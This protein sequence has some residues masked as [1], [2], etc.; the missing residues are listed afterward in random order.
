[1]DI[2]ILNKDKDKTLNEMIP[3]LTEC[4]SNFKE[5]YNVSEE[6]NFV[7]YAGN[8]DE[9]GKSVYNDD[10]LEDLAYKCF[11]GRIA[12]ISNNQLGGSDKSPYRNY[13]DWRSKE[14]DYLFSGVV[15]IFYVTESEYFGLLANDVYGRNL[16]SSFI[17]INN[18]CGLE[19][20]TTTIERMFA[21]FL[22]DSEM[23]LSQTENKKLMKILS[24][25]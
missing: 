4:Y 10:A 25:F 12:I 5:K 24:K 22:T 19:R 14:V 21:Y 16:Q 20:D 6:M 7:L 2:I 13:F 8:S 9:D 23:V 18:L 1:M 3:V 11:Q 17:N 15:P